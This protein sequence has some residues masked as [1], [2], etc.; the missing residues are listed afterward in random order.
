MAAV[1]ILDLQPYVDRLGGLSESHL[2]HAG[3]WVGPHPPGQPEP[4]TTDHWCV[5]PWADLYTKVNAAWHHLSHEG[6]TILYHGVFRVRGSAQYL[7]WLQVVKPYS[8]GAAMMHALNRIP[9]RRAP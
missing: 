2:L 1:P 6:Y 4:H 9:S 8:Q 7:G 3:W 5:G